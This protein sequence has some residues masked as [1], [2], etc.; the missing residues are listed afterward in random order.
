MRAPLPGAL[1]LE[2]RGE[3]L[4]HG[5]ERAGR[6]VGDLDR[7]EPGRGVLEHTGPAE[8]VD[9]VARLASGGA[10]RAPKPVIEQ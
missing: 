1:A 7:R 8:V 9:V 5:A 2:E 6:E 10:R 3:H 4:R